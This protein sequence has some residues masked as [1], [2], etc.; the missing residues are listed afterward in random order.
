M[1]A[2][3]YLTLMA[4]VM[5]SVAT[6]ARA[7]DCTVYQHRDYGGAYWYLNDLE[8]LIAVDDSAVG[9]SGLVGIHY[10]PD[11]ND[12]I[13]SFRLAPACMLRTYEHFKSFPDN[14]G[15]MYREWNASMKY[16]GGAWNDKITVA[17]CI[18][19]E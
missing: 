2:Y 3:R 17:K 4:L 16:V 1:T 19:G 11:W 15:G 14:G 10:R 13:S 8:S 5:V 9:M 6:E 7:A 18:C 12:T